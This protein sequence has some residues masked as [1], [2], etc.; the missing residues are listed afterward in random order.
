MNVVT[1]IANAPS[2]ARLRKNAPR[3]TRDASAL[4][5]HVLLEANVALITPAPLL[6][7]TALLRSATLLAVFAPTANALKALNAAKTVPAPLHAVR[8]E[9]Y[10]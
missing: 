8:N 2:L 6:A 10:K 1:L 7:A 4:P 5:V 3:F 9:L